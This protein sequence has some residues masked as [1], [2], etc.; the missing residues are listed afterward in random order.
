MRQKA[1]SRDC[2]SSR[3]SPIHHFPKSNG[4]ADG[5]DPLQSVR[6]KG[7]YVLDGE[8]GRSGSAGKVI[9]DN[10]TDSVRKS[11]DRCSEAPI[12]GLHPFCWRA[13]LAAQV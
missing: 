10:L 2:G 3:T 8:S 12:V 5:D 4:T 13:P 11:L 7:S 6:N 9:L 1:G